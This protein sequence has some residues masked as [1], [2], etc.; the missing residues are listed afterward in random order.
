LIEKK[1]KGKEIKKTKIKEKENE[2]FEHI[3]DFEQIDENAF[4]FCT[5]GYVMGTY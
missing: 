3:I 2:Q 4:Y 1:Q 5:S